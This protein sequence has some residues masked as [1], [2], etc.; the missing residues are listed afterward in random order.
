MDRLFGCCRRKSPKRTLLSYKTLR[1]R[2]GGNLAVPLFQ[3]GSKL[4]VNVFDWLV[5]DGFWQ[6][7][8]SLFRMGVIVVCYR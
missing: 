4:G 2:F 7:S 5:K 1:R 6:S 8:A 3:D